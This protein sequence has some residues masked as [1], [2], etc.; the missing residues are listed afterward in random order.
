MPAAN[1]VKTSLL[2]LVDSHG[3]VRATL[4]FVD[5]DQAPALV[6]LDSNG[7]ERL[8]V[9]LGFEGS[10]MVDLKDEKGRIG[11]DICYGSPDPGDAR[12]SIGKQGNLTLLNLTTDTVDGKSFGRI[13]LADSSNSEFFCKPARR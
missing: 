8:H 5:A 7:V 4:G 13:S 12:I 6:M 11:I 2:E 9:G 10:P 3:K 1:A